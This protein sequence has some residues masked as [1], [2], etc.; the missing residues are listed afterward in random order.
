[1]SFNIAHLS[2]LAGQVPSIMWKSNV[3]GMKL[4]APM[5]AATAT[6]LLANKAAHALFKCEVD[7]TA[8]KVIRFGAFV[9][10]TAAALYATSFIAI[11]TLTAHEALI[12]VGANVALDV[13]VTLV[14]RQVSVGF[15]FGSGIGS[16]TAMYAPRLITPFGV[17]GG[18]IGA[19][20]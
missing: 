15:T 18:I 7:S 6:A 20:V 10:G 17:T 2:E 9:A 13:L 4:F 3:I 8:S 5:A 1:M 19:I 14:M 12:L 16:L 11:G